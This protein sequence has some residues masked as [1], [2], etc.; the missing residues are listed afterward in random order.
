MTVGHRVGSDD[1]GRKLVDVTKDRLG[2][3]AI[4]EVGELVRRGGVHVDGAP[5]GINDPVPAGALLT[6]SVGELRALAAA[7]R[8]T[9]PWDAS[10]TVVHEDDHL[11][12]VDKPAGMHVHPLGA[13][14]EDTLVGAL[15]WRAGARPD[16]PWAAWRPRPTHRLDR[17]TSGLVL[18]AKRPEVQRAVDELRAAGEVHRAYRAVVE[19]DVTEDSGTIDAP[20]G[21]DPADDRR[22]AVT[23]PGMGQAAATH[24]C[25]V[26][27]DGGTTVLD[28]TLDTGRTHQ[29]RTHLAHLGHPIAGDTRYGAAATDGPGIAL[30]AVRLQLPHP[31]TRAPLDVHPDAD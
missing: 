27:R 19:G 25:V 15:L 29:L 21:I 13:H 17:A 26:R 16:A 4:T 7:D 14:R 11:V 31:V 23:D 12:V 2:V 1:A 6:L 20:I 18:V 3:V 10:L 5:G 9:P 24:W 22:R 28:L 30:R 8:L